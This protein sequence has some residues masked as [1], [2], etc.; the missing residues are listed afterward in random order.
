MCQRLKDTN[1]T[2]R[3]FQKRDV[4]GTK[5]PFKSAGW[6]LCLRQKG[7]EGR[8]DGGGGRGNSRQEGGV[9]IWRWK[10]YPALRI[11]V[12]DPEGRDL[13]EITRQVSGELQPGTQASLPCNL[14]ILPLQ[15]VLSYNSNC[16]LRRQ[17]R[18]KI[19]PM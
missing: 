11:Q 18:A 5:V 9:K 3:S 10:G 12:E 4:S 8:E 13:T 7:N 19:L 14:F 17:S 1:L 6:H 2:N 15:A 16:S